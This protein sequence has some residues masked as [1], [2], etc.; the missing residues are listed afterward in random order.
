MLKQKSKREPGL[1]TRDDNVDNF[2]F[3]FTPLR[4]TP[5]SENGFHHARIQNNFTTRDLEIRQRDVLLH[6]LKD[7]TIM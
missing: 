1:V 3:W 5:V 6:N 2:N 7:R 4:E